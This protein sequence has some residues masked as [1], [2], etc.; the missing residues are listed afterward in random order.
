MNWRIKL[1]IIAFI[2]AVAI[3]ILLQSLHLIQVSLM[4][5]SFILITILVI[6][7]F[8]GAISNKTKPKLQPHV[9]WI[10]VTILGLL[11]LTTYISVTIQGFPINSIQTPLESKGIKIYLNR[12]PTVMIPL[13]NAPGLPPRLT[14]LTLEIIYPVNNNITDVKISA[15]SDSIF[16]FNPDLGPGSDPYKINENVQGKNY[17]LEAKAHHYLQVKNYTDPYTMYIQYL[18]MSNEMD[19]LSL[20]FDWP[21]KTMDLNDFSYFWIVLIGV[22]VSRVLSIIL[23]K[24]SEA[25]KRAEVTVSNNPAGTTLAAEYKIERDALKISLNLN[26]GIWIAFSFVIALLIFASFSGQVDP[27]TSILTNITLAFGFGFGF[28]KVLEVAKKF[29][30]IA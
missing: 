12:E 3:I 29:E 28:D 8:S 16:T 1:P 20:V 14:D 24:L 13:Y 19:E 17:R 15:S 9:I 2:V 26:D 21:A 5:S 10:F 18:N 7:V 23:N 30:D 6:I 27:T 11:A 25:K 4:I 22:M